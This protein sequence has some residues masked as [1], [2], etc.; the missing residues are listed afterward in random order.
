MRVVRNA[1]RVSVI[2]GGVVVVAAGFGLWRA[3]MLLNEHESARVAAFTA[4]FAAMAFIQGCVILFWDRR[5]TPTALMRPQAADA[6]LAILP[7]AVIGSLVVSLPEVRDFAR[8]P[9]WLLLLFLGSMVLS[10]RPAENALLSEVPRMGSVGFPD[11]MRSQNFGVGSLLVAMLFTGMYFTSPMRVDAFTPLI[12]MLALAQGAV[13]IWRM[14]EQHRISK[15]GPLLSGM[16]IIWLRANHVNQGHA[17]AVKELR[18]MYPKISTTHAER[19]IEN[20]YRTEEE[21]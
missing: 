2:G 21:H 15:A 11:W 9:F 14:V 19:L 18:A 10:V 4:G 16:Q 20:L 7:A 17:A 8:P 5:S 13:S 3:A 12:I 1:K 6:V